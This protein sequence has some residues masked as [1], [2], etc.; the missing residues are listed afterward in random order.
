MNVRRFWVAAVIH[1]ATGVAAQA[2]PWVPPAGEGTLSLTFQNYYV[3]GHFDVLGRKNP[4]G[5]THARAMLAEVDFGLTDTTALTVTLPFIATKYTGPDQYEVGRIPTF[6]GPLDDREYHGTFQDLRIEA[7]R[8]WWAGPVAV[9]PLAGVTIP[10][11]QYETRGEAVA[12][13]HRREIQGGAAAGADLNRLL[14]GAYVDGRYALAVAERI[15]GFSSVKSNIDVE[16]GATLTERIGLRGMASWQI[17]HKGPTIL[18]LADHDWSGHDRFIVSSY[19]NVGGGVTVGLTRNTELHA[20]WIATISGKSG[21]HQARMLAVGSSWSF[22][23]GM[24]DFAS[25]AALT[26]ERSRS[27]LPA[28]EF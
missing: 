6:P 22:G 16:G 5:A 11:H 1:L 13:K 7:R 8:V 24:G 15:H 28:R 21:A 4:N 10:T 25:A 18:Q 27:N 14:R 20:V 26:T 3:V 9:A 19:F 17:R 23:S 2:Q 12:G